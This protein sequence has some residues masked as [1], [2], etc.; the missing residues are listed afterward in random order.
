MNL[1]LHQVTAIAAENFGENIGDLTLA[2]CFV[3]DLSASLDFEET[4]MACG[5]AF[6]IVI[7][8]EEAANLVT[9]DLLAAYIEIKLSPLGAIWPPA[10]HEDVR[11]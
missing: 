11:K 8:N 5:E 2:T 6:G 1:I 3:E 4:I 9:I 7:P 10:P